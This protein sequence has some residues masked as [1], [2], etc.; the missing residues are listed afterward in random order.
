MLKVDPHRA[1][2]AGGQLPEAGKHGGQTEFG[3]LPARDDGGVGNAV[4]DGN[5]PAAYAD[6]DF[7]CLAARDDIA[8]AAMQDLFETVHAAQRLAKH[9][10][11]HG[12]DL[13]TKAQ[14]DRVVDML[15]GQLHQFHPGCGGTLCFRIGKK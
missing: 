4:R 10:E 5:Q 8:T 12:A 7:L 11:I 6:V 3:I 13:A 2:G 1:H 14:A 9:T 15:A